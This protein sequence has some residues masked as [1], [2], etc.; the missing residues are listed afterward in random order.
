[1]HNRNLEEKKR[2]L[3]VDD[4]RVLVDGLTWR[5]NFESDFEVCGSAQSV[6]EGLQAIERLQP[7]V[8][9]IDLSLKGSHGLDLVKDMK[10]QYPEVPSL[11]LSMHDE[12]VYAERAIRAGAKGYVMKD[13]S[14]DT[15][16][17]AVRRVLRGETYMSQSVKEHIVNRMSNLPGSTEKV[18]V[19]VLSDRELEV[20]RLLGQG[21]RPRHIADKLTISPGTVDTHCKRIRIKLDLDTMAEVVEYAA[22]WLQQEANPS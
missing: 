20:F 1:M 10:I 7:D 13:Q 17:E 16:V 2:I 4:H 22:K 8:V 5:L 15:V 6:T 9:V 21:M 12:M 11:V 18:S 3:I 19:E 14:F